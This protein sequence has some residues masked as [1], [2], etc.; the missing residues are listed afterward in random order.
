MPTSGADEAIGPATGREILLAGFL[1]A[2]V[3]LE[4]PQR[5]GKREAGH[6]STLPIAVC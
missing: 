2:E 1:S 6:S 5:L 4:L 3:A